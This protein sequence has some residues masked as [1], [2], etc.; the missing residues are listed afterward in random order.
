M[1][2][3]R[4]GVI[5]VGVNCR[6]KRRTKQDFLTAG[7]CR[8]EKAFEGRDHLIA[9]QRLAMFSICV[10]S[11]IYLVSYIS[12]RT[13]YNCSFLRPLMYSRD[14]KGDENTFLLYRGGGCSCSYHCYPN[15]SAAQL[16]CASHHRLLVA[17]W[18]NFYG[19]CPFGCPP[20]TRKVQKKVLN[21]WVRC[22]SL[23]SVRFCC[24]H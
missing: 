17:V 12:L 24:I 3:V 7:Q 4:G 11:P 9:K 10:C 19:R 8:T 15:D 1:I 23:A 18:H 21:V 5:Y 14:W 20:N 6:S 2:H 16:I 13:G 22:V